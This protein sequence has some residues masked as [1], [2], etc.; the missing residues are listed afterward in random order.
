MHALQ[1]TKRKD[2]D[3]GVQVCTLTLY[4]VMALRLDSHVRLPTSKEIALLHTYSLTALA[5]NA[6][7]RVI[8]RLKARHMYVQSIITSVTVSVV[9]QAKNID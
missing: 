9:S 5:L 2:F 1:V 4:R 3:T 8:A 7:T 6:G